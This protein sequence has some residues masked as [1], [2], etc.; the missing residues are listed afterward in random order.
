MGSLVTL[1]QGAVIWFAA[2]DFVSQEAATSPSLKGAAAEMQ[3]YLEGMPE[4]N[5]T[6][7][8]LY[9]DWDG[10]GPALAEGK[11]VPRERLQGI[12]SR[13][14]GV[15]E[16]LDQP[17]LLKMREEL[18]RLLESAQADVPTGHP[19]LL[20]RFNQRLIMT[21]LDKLARSR[22]DERA[23][24][25]WIAG[26][27][28]TGNAVTQANVSARLA[29]LGD[30]A[31]IEVR[32]RGTVNTPHTLAQNG[33]FQVHGSSNSAFDGVA[34]LYLED[35]AVRLTEPR[36][37]VQTNSQLSHVDGPRLLT[38]FAY[39][40]AQERQG[41]GEAEGE[42]IIAARAT[43]EFKSELSVE[44]RSANEQISEH[45]PYHVLLKRADLVP[46]SISTK[47]TASAAEVGM[48]FL[49]GASLTPPPPKELAPETGFE[50]AIHESLASAFT[51]NFLRGSWWTDQGFT[52]IQKDL[53]GGN[54][55]EMLIGST[56]QRWSV[57]WDWQKPLTAK[58]SPEFIEYEL[59]FSKARIDDRRLENGLRVKARF[60]PSVT[61]WGLEFRRVGSVEVYPFIPQQELS[62]EDAEFFKRKFSG[63]FDDIVYLDGLSPPAGGGWDGLAAYTISG[64]RLEDGWFSL[65]A[66]KTAGDLGPIAQAPEISR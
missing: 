59:A 30:R 42:A 8:K 18:G 36:F 25:N 9:L 13:F 61:R 5:R 22:T 26:A 51:G 43:E 19:A 50:I 32:L 53:T 33:N 47:L 56:P 28:V 52:R 29:S 44:L 7:W 58:V 65:D 10:W 20:V 3:A 31:A 38:G 23:T 37:S 16:G 64:V 34:Y 40:R 11:P 62:R 21:E 4:P 63:L 49:G 35:H 60:V 57:R 39:R 17:Q 41:Q 15:Y 24:G 12:H 1:L 66:R 45:G 54:T 14:F 48:R 27:W 46:T 2:I 55:N 6:D